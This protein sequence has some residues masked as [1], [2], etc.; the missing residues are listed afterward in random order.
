MRTTAA[1]STLAGGA[2]TLGGSAAHP[3]ITTAYGA[4]RGTG[5]A[6]N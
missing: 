5:P 6:T 4:V 2:L 3:A 1:I